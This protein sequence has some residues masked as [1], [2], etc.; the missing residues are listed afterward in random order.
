VQVPR[1]G[2]EKKGARH[3]FSAFLLFIFPPFLSF[4]T[5]RLEQPPWDLRQ[6]YARARFLRVLPCI[7]QPVQSTPE[8]KVASSLPRI[9]SPA[10]WP[11]YIKTRR[12]PGP[13]TWSPTLHS[14]TPHR[15]TALIVRQSIQLR[16]TQVCLHLSITSRI[17]PTVCAVAQ[18]RARTYTPATSL[19]QAPRVIAP[20]SSHPLHHHHHHHYHRQSTANAP[21]APPHQLRRPCSQLPAL[22]L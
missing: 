1:L 17:F 12:F 20:S 3:R 19:Q 10:R 18:G 4:D 16:S 11:N 9:P 21:Q 8:P 15:P 13:L 5:F 2:R 22:S 14:C 6:P 7:D